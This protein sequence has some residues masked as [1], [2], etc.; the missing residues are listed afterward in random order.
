MSRQ[1]VRDVSAAVC[2][3]VGRGDYDALRRLFSPELA[4]GFCQEVA[5]IKEAF[6]DYAGTNEL[7]IVEGDRVATR[8]VY[9]GTHRGTFFDIPATGKR[10][11]FTGMSIDRVVDGRIVETAV[12]WD[13]VGVLRQ[14]GATRL[15]DENR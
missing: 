3:A 9:H 2:D 6:P 14:L 12:E 10:V 11:T 13:L 7:Y 1:E 15:P 8:W 5:A 4:P